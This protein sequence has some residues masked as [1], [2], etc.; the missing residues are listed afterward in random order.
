MAHD[1]YSDNDVSLN[2][3]LDDVT[4]ISGEE[5]SHQQYVEPTNT[6]NVN[7]TPTVPLMMNLNNIPNP[8]DPEGS[9]LHPNVENLR[10][11]LQ[12]QCIDGCKWTSSLTFEGSLDKK[13][14]Q[15]MDI[16]QFIGDPCYKDKK[17]N[18][19]FRVYLNPIKYPVTEELSTIA[20]LPEDASIK[21]QTQSRFKSEAYIKLSKDIR[22]AC[23]NCAFNLVQNGNQKLCL[24]RS[25]LS[26][27]NRFSCQK[28]MIHKGGIRDLIG[29]REFRRYTFRNDRKNQR[30][31]GRQ[32]CR[33]GYS[34]RSITSQTRC[35]FFFYI[36]FD[37][38]GFYIEPGYGN[39]YHSHHSPLNKASGVS[40]KDGLEVEDNELI[41]DMADGQA[42]DA[43]IQNVLFNKTGKLVA[44]STIRN[45]TK[46]QKR[47][48]VN[49]SDFE[50][51]FSGRR[52][53]DLSATEFM[54]TY[55]R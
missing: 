21:T 14:Y 51:I 36:N 52:S 29:N 50:N 47:L 38:Y 54:M 2:D 42:P 34:G 6:T 7:P 18:K 5:T 25:G 10:S 30:E 13:T 37:D 8:E 22:D 9:L 16:L 46:I 24:K 44:R 1:S 55:C 41:S 43:Q 40:G 49:D 17:D 3:L 39:K 11:Y 19:A 31:K 28:Y 48:V 35:K 12:K 23:G 20:S 45:I 53:E 15:D 26:I 4:S 27:R 33:R 32:K